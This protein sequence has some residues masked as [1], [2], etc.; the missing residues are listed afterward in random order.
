MA[1]EERRRR[2]APPEVRRSE[3]IEL[4][5]RLFANRSYDEISTDEIALEAG[6][7]KGPG[8]TPGPCFR[9]LNQ[10]GG[11]CLAGRHPR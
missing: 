8:W 6:I 4:G 1:E 3:L 5:I 7:A 11:A 9:F 10:G 2:R